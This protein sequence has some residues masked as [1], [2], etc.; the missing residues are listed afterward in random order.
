MTEKMTI[1]IAATF[2][3]EPL[4]DHLTWWCGQF[5]WETTLVFA[6]YN[7]VFQQFVDA[8]G[9]FAAHSD[10]IHVLL[11]RWEDALRAGAEAPEEEQAL[12]VLQYYVELVQAIK[13]A[14]RTS[15][16]LIGLL[17]LT[18]PTRLPPLA[19]KQIRLLH[20]KLAKDLQSVAHVQ[21][22]DLAELGEL[23]PIRSP[24]NEIGDQ[25]GHI[26]YTDEYYAVLGAT[27]ARRITAYRSPPFKLI[28]ADCD[29][30]LWKGVSSEEGY[31]G[32][33][34]TPSHRALQQ[35]LLDKVEEG[36]LLA[37][38][39]KNHEQAVWDVFDHHEDMVLRREHIV[40]WRI[41]WQPKSAN[42]AAIAAE[43]KL[44]LDSVIFIDDNL[45][46]CLEV[47]SHCPQAL[48]L[49]LPLQEMDFM[50]FLRRVWAFDKWVVTSEDRQR[51]ALYAAEQLRKEE[52]RSQPFQ[53]YLEQLK[54]RLEMKLL[55][56]SELPRAAQLTQRTNQFVLSPLRRTED[57]LTALLADPAYR[58]WTIAASDKFGHYGLSGLVAGRLDEET[59][60]LD[61]FLLSCRIL[62]RKLEEAVLTALKKIG[63]TLG[64]R[65]LIATFTDTG[66]NAP[67]REFLAATGWTLEAGGRIGELVCSLE[68]EH[69]P[70]ESPYVS[71]ALWVDSSGEA[72]DPSSAASPSSAK[73]EAETDDRK[74]RIQ[75]AEDGQSAA[76]DFAFPLANEANL[77]RRSYLLPLVYANAEQLLTLPLGDQGT[78]VG[79]KAVSAPLERTTA[80][81][82]GRHGAAGD[83]QS[84]YDGA[85]GG[86]E[87]TNAAAVTA[88]HVLALWR[89]YLKRPQ[90]GLDD[91][92]FESGG[93]SLLA[94]L[95]VA[96]V[97]QEWGVRLPLAEL[98]ARQTA[99]AVAGAVHSLLVS[100]DG[101]AEADA[102]ELAPI[103]LAPPRPHYELSSAQKRMYI[104]Q[105]LEPT[106]TSYNL[107]Q[108]ICLH[109]AL[110]AGRLTAA[111][112]A[113]IVRHESLRTSFELRDG[114]PVQIVHDKVDFAP[115]AARV[116]EAEAD[117]RAA[118]FVRPF[119][120]AQAPLMRA[121]LLQ[122]A[123]DR[124]ELLLDWHHIVADGISVTI[125][126]DELLRLYDG[127]ALPTLAVQYKDY[128]AWQ[129]ERLDSE[130]NRG[131]MAYWLDRFAGE[132]LPLHIATDFPR[133]P[134][135]QFAGSAHPFRVEPAL[136]AGLRRLAGESGATLY[137]VLLALY[138][139]L[140]ARYSGQSELVIGSPTAGRSHADTHPLVGMFVHTLALRCAPEHG[141]TF[142]D[143]LAEVKQL[144]LDAFAHED[145]PFEELVERLDL[146]R[147]RSRNPLFDTMLTLQNMDAQP[148]VPAGL[149]LQELLLP[150]ASSRLD[151]TMFVKEQED[152][153]LACELEY[154]T[155]LFRAESVERLAGHWLALMQAVV[156]QPQAR[157]GELELL[158]LAERTT[159]L[160]TFNDTAA[161]YGCERFVHEWL[162]EQARRA[163]ERIAVRFGR[164]R[165]TYRELN[166][167]ANRL[168]R[169]LRAA[170]VGPDRPVAVIA[171]RSWEMLVA[172]YAVLKAGGAY[173]PV[174]PH[175]PQER[176]RYLLADSAAG[177]VLVQN[178]ALE[179]KLRA[180]GAA[181]Q[182]SEAS[183]GLQLSGLPPG[184]AGDKP[185]GAATAAVGPDEAQ[186]DKGKAG[187]A[188]VDGSSAPEAAVWL[189]LDD[190]AHYAQDGGD[191]PTGGTSRN[192]A[193]IIYTSGS[194]GQPKGVMVEHT[195]V[196]NRLEW[197]QKAYPLSAA[198]VI[199]Q[200][201]PITFDVSVWELFW[202]S[203]AGASVC[204]L[205]P[206]GE[207]DPACLVRTIAEQ[208]VSV[209]HFVPSMLTP[210][211]QQ[212]AEVERLSEL[213]SLSRVFTSGEAL[214]ARQAELCRE[215]L[216][217][218]LGVDLVNLYGPTEATVDV[219]YYDVFRHELSLL[220]PIGRPIDNTQLYV[221]HASGM[222]QPIGAA[223]ELCIAGSGLARG[224]WQRP[225]LT[226]E[227]FIAASYA[228]GGRL[229]RTGDLARWLPSGQL[230][231]LGR[232]DHQVKIRGFRI[233]LGEIEAQLLRHEAVAKCVV[234]DR[235]DEAGDKSICAYIVASGELTAAGLREHL[236]AN[237]PDY[238][239]PASFMRVAD[240]P[241]TPN[242]KAD[243]RALL[244]TGEP[245]ETG[246]AYA[247]P[248]SVLEAR[249]AAIWQAVL[250]VER[251]GIDDS[252]FAAGGHSLKAML[253]VSRISKELGVDVPLRRLFERPTIRAVSEYAEAAGGQAGSFAPI[254]PLAP[255]EVYEV[256]SAQKR[257][258][259]LQ[260]L[261]P[262]Q[263]TYNIP[264]L[265]EL[266]GEVDAARLE[267]ALL[268]LIARHESLRTSFEL[269]DG[270]PV[271]RVHESVGFQLELAEAREAEVADRF[272][273]FVRPFDLHTAPL[274]RAQLLRVA[275]EE[276]GFGADAESG[277]EAKVAAGAGAAGA[278]ASTGVGVRAADGIE[279]GTASEIG[280]AAAP[281][282]IG[283]STVTERE[284]RD[285]AAAARPATH[286]WRL[287]L[288]I[289]HSIAD[290][291]TIALL[292]DELA[293]LYDGDGA[294]LPE[295]GVQ[296]KDYAAWQQRQLQSEAHRRMGAYWRG[297]FADGGPESLN[298]PTDYP[299][300]AVQSYRGARIAATVSPALAA[301][302]YKL[303]ESGG[304]T[305]FMVLMA[306]YQTLL[307]IYSGQSDIAVGTPVAGRDHADTHGIAGVFINTLVLRGAPEG[308]KTFRELLAEVK[309]QALLAYEHQGFPFE[310]LVEQLELTRDR[311]RHPLFDTMLILQNGERSEWTS[312]ALTL[313]GGSP[314][315]GVAKFDLTL[316]AREVGGGIELEWEYA[317]ALFKQATVERMSGHLLHLLAQIAEEPDAP[318]GKLELLAGEERRQVIEVFNDTAADYPRE[319]TLHGL[320]EQA[321]ERR[322]QQ[323]AVSDERDS[324]TYAELNARAN[325]LARRLRERGVGRETPVAIVAER[326]L[327][328]IVGIYAIL[329][330]GG[331]YVP[332]D[333][334]H[335]PARLRYMLDDSQAAV[336]LAQRKWLEQV[337]YAGATLLLEDAASYAADGANLLPAS[338]SGDLAYI[339]Y[340]SGTTGHPKGV[341]IEHHSVINRLH[342]MQKAYPLTDGDVILQKTPVTFDVSVWELFWWA[343]AG[344]TLR[345]LAPQGEKD[346]QTMA[347]TIERAGVT[348]MHFVPSMF[349]LFLQYAEQ[350]GR[351]ERLRSL[352]TVFTSGEALPLEQAELF[353]RLFGEQVQLVNLYGPTEAT[354]DVSHVRCVPGMERMT[355]G[356]PIDNHRLLIVG[357]AGRLQPIGVAGELWIGGVGLARGYWNRPE[358]TAEKFA[359]APFGVGE[360][361]YRTGDLARWLADGSIE[362]IGRIDHQVKIRGQR[363]ELGEIAAQLAR[364]GDV[365]EAL[366]DARKGADGETYLC[367]YVVLEPAST[368]AES[369]GLREFL[370]QTLPAYMVPAYIVPLERIPLSPSGKADRKALPEPDAAAAGA[371]DVKPAGNEIEAMLIGFWQRLLPHA[372]TIGVDDVFF[373]L[374]GDSIKLVQLQF[375]LDEAY[376][377]RV[378]VADLFAY[379]TIARLAAYL[380][381]RE[382]SAG[383]EAAGVP[384]PAA[385]F[386]ALPQQAGT[387]PYCLSAADTAGLHRAAELGDVAVRDLLAAALLYLLYD[388]AETSSVWLL[389]GDEGVPDVCRYRYAFRGDEADFLA[390]AREVAQSQA[391]AG[392]GQKRPGA[393]AN[394]LQRGVSNS[395]VPLIA[396][397]T[398]GGAA[399]PQ[400]Q[401]NE[402]IL[403]VETGL[404]GLQLTFAIGARLHTPL[405]R[406]WVGQ[407]VG[408]LQWL[409]A[410]TTMTKEETGIR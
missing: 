360:R 204:L 58:I 125:L 156:Q 39:S 335:P 242:G 247:A 282:S 246:T 162:E 237:V 200:K 396:G 1:A 296:Y 95:F 399:G 18:E 392:A 139:V 328:L 287:L 89:R 97:G 209:L 381:E 26:P 164:E 45:A 276:A 34:I 363:I 191:L 368:A 48:T 395:I 157:L 351:M 228:P 119:D 30:T 59:L 22:I 78:P 348:V 236:L 189:R 311:S 108:R 401:G 172:V 145:Y 398:S 132:T 184:G 336:L 316:V 170:G 272:R 234:L 364:H 123:D 285:G 154:S 41:N 319:L 76:Y 144:A 54:L 333:P 306:A 254:E 384:L 290:G 225:E 2:T 74:E 159:L 72:V 232:I 103:E 14:L 373:D 197:M 315:I 114:K 322:P 297:V 40:A 386:T 340:T 21:V 171:E 146:P 13:Q 390:Y 241:L 339:L 8:S 260:R 403:Y 53:Q 301:S 313:R 16:L 166:E 33:A 44:G 377:G 64:A 409:L 141:K 239:V 90:L 380:Q 407:Y 115:Y 208:R 55:H 220:V 391:A 51:T 406:D 94:A 223:G 35:F 194:T 37:L 352:R 5:G 17:P 82:T 179:H 283:T 161:P 215:R 102:A 393:G 379:P 57:E 329:K 88:E 117:A 50:P 205:E 227:K 354:V 118:A 122:T 341:M 366:V 163:P 149:T 230:E 358:L 52:A 371:R 332:L 112:T 376:P 256:S 314:D 120:L 61:S 100:G 253:A 158:P 15:P 110:D 47:M 355:I 99:R 187:R 312:P 300:P 259:V 387:Y 248:R 292:L 32:V 60:R 374:G 20:D 295:L 142:H 267:A 299:R 6:P 307:A 106:Q 397:R 210:F 25:I 378:S 36:F 342:W 273:S 83:T 63:E 91:S 203:A 280:T 321:A 222:L 217:V 56:P 268:C 73:R 196:V 298:L 96:R 71:I 362:Y 345:L 147:D 135:Q 270:V 27:L 257:M 160:E 98:F 346:P 331:A 385:Y 353:F 77:L 286:R 212:V 129:Q 349:R 304:A 80:A 238:M 207:K 389:S 323:V 9:T 337:D 291:V 274:F 49:R 167:A 151:L 93:N 137:M 216:H 165:R 81:A 3:A 43:L 359:A 136:A 262:E 138:S 240:I 134:V 206:G 326:S 214:Q 305:L 402:L 263:V 350:G 261:E 177:I 127:Q 148:Y 369:G 334:A 79:L 152:G 201:T 277:A 375:W 178:A 325:R 264:H 330:A 235:T 128:A 243:R 66:K 65:R 224:Y 231:Y 250:G 107:P 233:E 356:R 84:G 400:P 221:V 188:A 29:H 173:V 101:Q 410:Q 62:G 192:L 245:L 126:L 317:M 130:R 183:D 186:A 357:P 46:E 150:T 202:W 31:A 281:I 121:E 365:R 258:Y 219:T 105:Q 70:A 67:F 327:E 104:M 338:G 302:L 195:S 131:H 185:A 86:S 38:C 229:Y 294:P 408:A 394:Q 12:A 218:P 140:L 372:A 405:M 23:Y 75:L 226:A 68:A 174:D 347:E 367:G 113:L 249:L 244:R 87:A 293:R 265:L 251:I 182:Q 279:M 309:E 111:L 109:G 370:R 344:Q 124:H 7:Q 284:A 10:G 275:D 320:L 198:D 271:Q 24:Y 383:D 288:D 42:I 252:F 324:L 190:P 180:A 116:D 361:M 176:I 278:G 181:G 255:Q 308:G 155:S 388:I 85:V 199:L 269:R 211:L 382:A 266:A 289:H 69:I 4:A 92:F 133:P 143:Y 193:Y 153:A 404:D 303:A 28:I 169:T 175:Y 310:E 19:A 318:L 213:S 168:A 11:L 343:L